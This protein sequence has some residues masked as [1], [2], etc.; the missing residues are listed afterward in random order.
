MKASSSIRFLFFLFVPFPP[1]LESVK[2][3]RWLQQAVRVCVICWASWKTLPVYRGSDR[4]GKRERNCK[5][6]WVIAAEEAME[7]KRERE[8]DR[9]NQR[10]RDSDNYER[11]GRDRESGKNGGGLTWREK[12][13][14]H[15]RE[16]QCESSSSLC[17]I[18]GRPRGSCSLGW[19]LMS[20]LQMI[21]WVCLQLLSARISSAWRRFS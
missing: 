12:S 13:T 2:H 9:E 8:S 6:Q 15:D 21:R 14:T 7:I 20:W 19:E 16:L 10:E 11:E 18:V 5:T 17:G 1:Q 4:R 3:V